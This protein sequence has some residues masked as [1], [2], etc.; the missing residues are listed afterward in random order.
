VENEDVF[1]IE[2]VEN[3]AWGLDDL[4]VAPSGQFLGSWSALGV[5]REL[6]HMIKDPTNQRCGGRLVLH[7]DEVGNRVEVG[8]GGFSPDYFSHLASRVLAWA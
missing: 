8:D 4:P 6:G 1:A 3:P 2:S 7:G 5:I